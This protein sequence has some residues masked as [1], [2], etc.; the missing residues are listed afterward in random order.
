MIRW[1]HASGR[2]FENLFVPPSFVASTGSY[3]IW[4]AHEMAVPELD[5]ANLANL[6]TTAKLALIYMTPDSCVANLRM[7]K[8]F[9]DGLPPN[10]FLNG[11]P[12]VA[13]ACHLILTGGGSI[14][15]GR[16]IGDVHAF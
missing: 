7:A 11:Q 4:A 9:V 14:A 12:C 5:Q 10:A 8:H 6:C 16:V 15:E 13:H 2:R 1:A 3:N